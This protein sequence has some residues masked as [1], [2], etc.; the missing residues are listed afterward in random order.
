MSD[1]QY[2]VEM[3]DDRPELSAD[4]LANRERLLR[5]AHA[6]LLAWHSRD[7]VSVSDGI[8]LTEED[9]VLASRLT[10]EGLLVEGPMADGLTRIGIT[11][12]GELALTGDELDVA[13]SGISGWM[14]AA[15]I[16]GGLSVY[17]LFGWTVWAVLRGC[18]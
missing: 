1:K 11:E 6:G 4:Q 13:C 3:G 12:R 16:L 2:V 9:A 15:L 7:L 10:H 14:W 8:A 5:I 18:P 17:T